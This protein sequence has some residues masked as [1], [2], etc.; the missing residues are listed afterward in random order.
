VVG[1][2]FVSLC[3]R[4]E[5]IL[6]KKKKGHWM[7]KDGRHIPYD[8]IEDDHLLNILGFLQHRAPYLKASEETSFLL[9]PAPRGDMACDAVDDAQRELMDMGH[10]DWL[11]ECH[12][13]YP[14][15]VKIAAERKLTIP[16]NWPTDDE[17]RR[18]RLVQHHHEVEPVF[19]AILKGMK[20]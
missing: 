12:D 1:G 11:Q 13:A 5:E 7:T 6:P 17:A 8:E 15:L 9:L 16:K 14:H 10:D 2:F 19:K 18:Q 4:E 3:F 20:K